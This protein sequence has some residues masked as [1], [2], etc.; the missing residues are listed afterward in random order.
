MKPSGVVI[1]EL[2]PEDSIPAITELLHEAYAP[3]AAKG[4][5]Y[6]ATHQDDATTARRLQG[7]MSFVSEVDGRIVGTITLR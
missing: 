1:R 5:R 6:L 2:L 7:G 4:F 3:L